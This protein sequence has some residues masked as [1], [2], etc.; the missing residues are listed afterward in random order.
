MTEL[1]E[2]K[3]VQKNFGDKYAIRQLDLSI[4]E[5]E[6]FVLVGPS[7][8]GKTTSLKMINGLS[9]PS[10]GE[11]FFKGKS[12]KNYNLQ[13]M[14]WQMGYVLQQIA[15]FPTM[16]VKQNIEV[17][18]EMLGWEK[19]KRSETSD[20]LLAKV[21]LDP[22]IYRDRMPQELSGGEQQRVGIV[23]ALAAN[24]EVILMD[25]PFSALD[26]LSRASLQELVLS[27]HKELG[28]TIVFVTHNMEEAIKLGNRIA[29]MKEGELIQCDTPERLLLHPENDFVRS[30]FEESIQ[31]KA[32]T[33]EQV[34]L[35]GFFE[36]EITEQ[37][38]AVELDTPLQQLFA[39]LE[40]V[41]KVSVYKQETP[42]GEI[43]R[44]NVFA[45]LSG[46]KG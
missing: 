43:S 30:F 40:E 16:T 45:F 27:L 34:I 38:R 6:I 35:A 29:V 17:I 10:N 18:P 9:L 39:Q 15:L 19:Q 26:P 24:P 46:K 5:G 36:K 3:N 14:R 1:I 28:T 32:Q 21:G 2:F 42:I 7:G 25:E 12:L 8:S 37:Q 41:E 20:Q 33:V 44:K 23:R 13:K 22:D 4:E 11:V 31:D